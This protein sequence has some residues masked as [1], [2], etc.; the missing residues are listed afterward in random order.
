MACMVRLRMAKL[1]RQMTGAQMLAVAF[2]P[3]RRPK[4]VKVCRERSIRAFSLLT[5]GPVPCVMA[6]TEAAR[7]EAVEAMLWRCRVCGLCP[8]V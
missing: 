8:G 3:P 1:P 2:L 6:A 5:A 4:R 7:L